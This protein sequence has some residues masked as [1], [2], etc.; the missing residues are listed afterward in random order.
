MTK[1]EAADWLGISPSALTRLINT[2]KVRAEEVG[3]R[4]VI[5]QSALEDHLTDANIIRA[6]KDKKRDPSSLPKFTN[7]SFFSG[8]GGLDIGLTKAGFETVFFADNY[9]EARMTVYKNHPSAALK[10]D[11]SQLTAPEVRAA[12]QI[13]DADITL[14]SGGPPC[15]AFSTAGARRAFDDPRGNVFLKFVEIATELQPQYIVIENVRGLLSIAYPT[16]IGGN[17]VKGGALQLILNKLS[18]AGYDV[19]FN[20]YNSANYGSPQVRERVIIIASRHDDP[21]PWLQPS[22]SDNKYWQHIHGLKPWRTFR[23]VMKSLGEE[24][25]HDYID[26]PEKRLKYF[27]LLKDGEYWTSLPDNLQ[28][29]AMGKAYHLSGGRTGFY[30]RIALDKPSP[31]LVTSPTM[32]ATDLCHP[33]ELRP[34]SVQEYKVIQ[35]FPAEWWIAGSIRDIYRQIGNAVPVQLGEAIGNTIIKHMHGEKHD[36]AFDNFPYSRYNGTNEKT[37]RS[38]AV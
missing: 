6:P 16:K 1:S 35:G 18:N 5:T 10:G 22:H 7:L 4:Q 13:G 21:V 29:E 8:A 36:S 24:T 38:G 34:L 32:P 31:T 2:G 14:V 20:L 27:R 33:L 17:P 3:K 12:A 30:R 11:I 9:K 15:Q 26:F 23:D 19:S 25:V 37:W 28:A